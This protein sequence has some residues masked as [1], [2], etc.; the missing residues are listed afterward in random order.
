MS[1]VVCGTIGFIILSIGIISS[2]ELRRLYLIVIDF[3]SG[4]NWNS[5]TPYPQCS[6]GN[7]SACSGSNAFEAML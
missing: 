5:L 6:G 1:S 2:T 4:V 7:F 3:K